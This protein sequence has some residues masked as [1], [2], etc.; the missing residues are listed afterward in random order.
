MTLRIN[1]SANTYDV[2]VELDE[3]T[4]QMT[5]AADE[6]DGFYQFEALDST[7]AFGGSSDSANFNLS[8][9]FQFTYSRGD[10]TFSFLANDIEA[11]LGLSGVGVSVDNVNVAAL[12]YTADDAE[13]SISKGTFAFEGEGSASV[14]GVDG[15]VASGSLKLRVNTTGLVVD[16]QFTLSNGITQSLVFVEGEENL[17]AAIGD[18]TV[19]V[20][21]IFNLSGDFSFQVLNDPDIGAPLGIDCY[22]IG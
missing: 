9:D 10:N 20:G 19:V 15:L 22:H 3:E 1:E 18:L 11:S 13:N 5:F 2:S 17:V 16:E 8:G 14:Q 4:V 12:I 6:T 7:L 21:D